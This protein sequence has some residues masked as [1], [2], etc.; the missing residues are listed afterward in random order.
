MEKPIGVP[1]D[2]GM[3]GKILGNPMEGYSAYDR[4]FNSWILKCGAADAYRNRVNLLSREICCSVNA[5]MAEGRRT[6]ILSM[7]SGVAYEVQRY[8]ENPIE[9]GEVNFTLVDFSSETL[10]EAERQ[11]RMLGRYPDGISLELHRSSVLDLANVAR[12]GATEPDVGG[13]EPESEY[14]LVYCAGLFDYLS[15]RL[16]ARVTKYLFSLVRPGGKVVVSNYTDLNPIK[17][18]MT[19]VMDW[20]L[21]YRS[22]SDFEEIMK[23]SLPEANILIETDNAGVEVYAL[24][25]N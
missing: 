3:L 18:W 23:K 24:I 4:I 16:I 8:I 14:D 22:A 25:R 21:I 12:G 7:A 9:G 17:A 1:G 13:Y 6:S 20:E 19:M 5:A 15:D 11:Y 2:F 10:A